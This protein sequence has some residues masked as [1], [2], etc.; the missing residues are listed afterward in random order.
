MG[1]R[2]GR[3]RRSHQRFPHVQSATCKRKDKLGRTGG[4]GS[5]A[6]RGTRPRD[7]RTRGGQPRPPQEHQFMPGDTSPRDRAEG[8]GGEARAGHGYTG[9]RPKPG[10]RRP[11]D[12]QPGNSKTGPKGPGATRTPGPQ[13]PHHKPNWCDPNH[14]TARGAGD[15]GTAEEPGHRRTGQQTAARKLG[16]TAADTTT[17]TDRTAGNKAG[18]RSAR[19]AEPPVTTHCKVAA[20]SY[21]VAPGV[22]LLC[23]GLAPLAAL[24]DAVAP[25]TPKEQ[26]LP[27]AEA[28]R[29]RSMWQRA[30]E[31]SGGDRVRGA[32]SSCVHFF[33]CA[34]MSEAERWRRCPLVR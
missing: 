18:A 14:P 22:W 28:E 1:R 5:K 3:G 25:M 34:A 27:Y 24:T 15:P 19:P 16:T 9:D 8:G 23:C 11:N 6:R 33:R 13:R 10:G 26:R 32:C 30:A 2:V 17:G 31:Q 4:G 29:C 7:H 12:Q 20:H 21:A